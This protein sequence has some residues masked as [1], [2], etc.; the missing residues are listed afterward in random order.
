MYAPPAP[1]EWPRQRRYIWTEDLWWKNIV[2]TTVFVPGAPRAA[3]TTK[4]CASLSKP[5]SLAP[6]ALNNGA[7]DAD[8]ARNATNHLQKKASPVVDKRE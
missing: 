8:A 7:M 1:N 6:N 5:P 3:P 2:A 4:K